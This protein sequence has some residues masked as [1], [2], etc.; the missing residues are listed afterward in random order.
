MQKV[1][2]IVGIC[3]NRQVEERGVHVGYKIL[4][5]SKYFFLSR[6]NILKNNSEITTVIELKSVLQTKQ[7]ELSLIQILDQRVET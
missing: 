6:H 1:S 4:V 5:F 7:I 3:Q 2:E